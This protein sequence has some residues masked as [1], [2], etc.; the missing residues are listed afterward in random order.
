MTKRSHDYRDYP[1]TY[2]VEILNSF[3]PK[4]QLKDTE[5]ATKN[6]LISSLSKL[7]RFKFVTTLFLEFKKIEND[8]ET[9]FTTFYFISKSRK[10]INESDIDDLFGSI[11]TTITS[12]IQKYLGKGSGLVIDSVIDNVVNISKYNHLL[13]AVMSN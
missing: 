4:L 11:Y 12:N 3:N 1:S 8:D 6:K 9:K 7:R 5:S 10:N 2:N 13:A